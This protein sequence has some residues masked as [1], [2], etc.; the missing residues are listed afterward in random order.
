MCETKTNFR[1]RRCGNEISDLER[2][3]KKNPLWPSL[4]LSLSLS[5]D[6]MPIKFLS[7]FLVS[8]H[9]IRKGPSAGKL[10]L[11]ASDYS[12]R[13]EAALLVY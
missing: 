6:A 4:P 8:V 13:K 1:Q 9:C 10:N 2:E 12:D 7:V 11:A 5:G 3:K